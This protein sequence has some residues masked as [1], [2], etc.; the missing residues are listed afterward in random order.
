M[1]ALQ[2]T[3]LRPCL[4]TGATAH[5]GGARR[6]KSTE[7]VDSQKEVYVVPPSPPPGGVMPLEP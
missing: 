2:D 6:G 7:T 5:K 4:F 1:S 3:A